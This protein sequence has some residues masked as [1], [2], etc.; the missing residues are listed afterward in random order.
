MG[1]GS[2]NNEQPETHTGSAICRQ[3]IA[4][5][6]II[7]ATY[8][9]SFLLCKRTAAKSC[10]LSYAIIFALIELDDPNGDFNLDQDS[11]P[12]MYFS[13]NYQEIQE[14]SRFIIRIKHS[15]SNRSMS[16]STGAF[17]MV[18]GSEKITLGGR[19]LTNGVD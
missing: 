8:G 18:E 2:C 11:G 9:I 17:M 6:E 4:S 13:S 1:N 10:V 12:A 16:Q 7:L 19:Q 14:E 5:L 3:R 15:Q